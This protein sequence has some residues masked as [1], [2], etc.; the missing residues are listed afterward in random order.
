MIAAMDE[1]HKIRIGFI[2][3]TW[4][5]ARVIETCLSSVLAIEDIEATVVLIDNGSTDYTVK[6]VEK[7]QRAKTDK[8]KI[9]RYPNNMGTTISRNN[10]I[11][12]FIGRQIDYICILDSDTVVNSSAMEQ[13][14][15]EMEA[16]PQYGIIGPKMMTSA[17]IPQ[18]SARCFPTLLEK[19]CKAMPFSPLQRL[20]EQMEQQYSEPPDTSSYLVDYL[21][22]AFWLIRPEVFESAGMLDEK[23]FYAPEDAEYCIRV[24]KAGYQVAYCPKA[25]IIHEWQR[26]SKRKIIS[27]INWEH[28]K[29][30]A[31]MFRKHHYL[32]SC[33]R[34]R[35]SF[36]CEGK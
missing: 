14:I 19:I 32:F 34:L 18:M 15:A 16:H 4:N 13:L 21:M 7:I 33:K 24:W 17:G 11:R 27:R 29:G 5:S 12:H 22:S 31:Y 30:L 26:L 35:Q 10:G 9:I 8:L 3:L 23:I 20:G 28:I 2:I 25:K 6:F 1:P 36:Q